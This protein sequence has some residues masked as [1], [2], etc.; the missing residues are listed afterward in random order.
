MV[1]ADPRYVN[2]QPSGRWAALHQ[3]AERGDKA[4][5]KFLL[6]QG[7]DT[8]LVTKEGKTPLDVASPAVRSL[9]SRKRKLDDG[10]GSATDEDDDDDDESE[11]GE[12]SDTDSP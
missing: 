1:L 7:A 3:F 10:S 8:K 9:L 11:Y 2:A 6:A 5:V 12:L 4:A